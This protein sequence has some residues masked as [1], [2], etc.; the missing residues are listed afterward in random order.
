MKQPKHHGLNVLNR[1]FK[2]GRVSITLAR[3]FYAFFS[4]CEAKADDEILPP[5]PSSTNHHSRSYLKTS[6][7][8]N[9]NTNLTSSQ[10]QQLLTQLLR[11][12][13]QKKNHT[14]ASLLQTPIQ[15]RSLSID[16]HDSLQQKIKRFKSS[17]KKSNQVKRLH[18][19]KK[20]SKSLL[21]PRLINS[22]NYYLHRQHPQHLMYI[23]Y[24]FHHNRFSND[25]PRPMLL[26]PPPNSNSR[27][28]DVV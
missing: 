17:H 28:V 15:S 24:L 18:L 5:T 19:L 13:N 6:S 3:L 8:M 22:R 7:L 9:S 10:H 2:H 12:E 20:K 27:R 4:R 21:L 14:L 1:S 25:C 16:P 23:R 26:V 11:I